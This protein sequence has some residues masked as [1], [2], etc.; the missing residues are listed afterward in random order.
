MCAFAWIIEFLNRNG[1]LSDQQIQ[2]RRRQ[3]QWWRFYDV[4]ELWIQWIPIVYGFSFCFDINFIQNQ[5]PI[6]LWLCIRRSFVFIDN[7]ANKIVDANKTKKKANKKTKVIN[8]MHANIQSHMKW[9]R[10]SLNFHNF[11]VCF[12]SFLQQREEV[13]AKNYLH[14]R[15]VFPRVMN[16][17]KKALRISMKNQLPSPLIL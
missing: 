6:I 7:G 8:E 2:R 4:C 3:W 10:N 9:C 5:R 16:S 1:Y 12:F 15:Q 13:T 14:F 11:F 17:F